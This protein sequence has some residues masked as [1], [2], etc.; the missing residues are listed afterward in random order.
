MAGEVYQALREQL[1]Q[2]SIGFP[3]TES[4]VELQILRRLFTEEQAEMFLQLSLMLETPEAIAQRTG[5]DSKATADLLHQMAEAGLIFRLRKGETL[6][7]G[8]VPFVVGIFEFQLNTMD[9]E[10]AR[11]LEDYME[12]AYD[13]SM[14]EVG[15]P[16][17]PIPVNRSIAVSH[18]VA[19]YD[20][21]REIFK[22]QKLIAVA[23]CICRVH[24]GLLAH[25]CD[26][27]KEVCFC[28]GSFGQYYIDKGMARQVDL[29]EALK[30][31]D[32][33]DEAAL[34]PQ[35]FNAQNPG[36][37]CNCCGDCCGVLRALKKTPKPVEMVVS[38][39]FAVV[40]PDECTGCETCLERCQ[41]DAIAIPDSGIAEIN[42]DRCI[43][44]G[45]CASTCP[46][47]A[48]RLQLKAQDQRPS[49]PASGQ[50]AYMEMAQK[51]GK[52]LIPLSMQK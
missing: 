44:C 2:Y 34:V 30:I 14:V 39:Y 36:G 51:R 8:A 41:M 3:A 24:Q 28:F 32:K 15:A 9:R 26:K 42:L 43:G 25:D 27:P 16:M 7:Y 31:L 18:P 23:D 49:P 22:N 11:M 29:E 21:A 35:P 6:K 46:T 38:S 52:S 10:L 50:Q 12:S 13:R 1:D 20:D 37:F 47:E 19:T 4:G 17:R 48:I 33:C 5:R 40:D 45:L